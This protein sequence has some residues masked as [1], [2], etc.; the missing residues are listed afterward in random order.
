MLKLALQAWHKLSKAQKIGI[1]VSTLL[2]IP[3]IVLVFTYHHKIV[4]Y[5]TPY[6][7]H[8]KSLS[9]GFLIPG[10]LCFILSFPPL[11]GHEIIAVLTG[12]VYGPWV[13]W[14]VIAVSTFLAECV[15]F[16]VF[17]RF[18]WKRCLEFRR[19]HP[20]DW[21]VFCRVV[22]EGGWWMLV[23]I[24]LSA[25]PGHF[26]TLG[27][28]SMEGISFFAMASAAAVSTP[29]MFLPVYV[30]HLLALSGIEDRK[31]SPA[32]YVVFAVTG[33]LTLAIGGWIYWKY[34]KIRKEMSAD[35]AMNSV[36]V[37]MA[38]RPVEFDV[39]E[40][41]DEEE[42][43]GLTAKAAGMG[44]SNEVVGE[45]KGARTP[46]VDD[47][48]VSPGSKPGYGYDNHAEMDNP[49]DADE[50]GRSNG[51]GDGV[52]RTVLTDDVEGEDAY[53]HREM[54]LDLSRGRVGSKDHGRYDGY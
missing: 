2:L 12:F 8:V 23:L 44:M 20:R 49:F 11:F 9:W 17:R 18:F 1:I 35:D 14:G 15:L 45:K 31:T 42:R 47:V 30:G 51:H 26:S 54:S 48:D 37:E 10:L 21:A 32:E 5:L 38:Y 29:K 39:D 34:W 4:I 33:V 13:G 25:I 46:E 16:V 24:R 52:L 19:G 7:K 28:A 41:G 27:F 36:G 50:R 43:V 40:D 3:L 53:D 6:A 22:E